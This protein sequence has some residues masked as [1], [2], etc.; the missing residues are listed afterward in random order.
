[1]F[2]KQFTSD[3]VFV[4]FEI[5]RVQQSGVRMAF[6]FVSRAQMIS[7]NFSGV[8]Q[9]IEANLNDCSRGFIEIKEA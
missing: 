2:F 6:L 3:C 4:D 1:L 7:Q 9:G 5:C 8:G